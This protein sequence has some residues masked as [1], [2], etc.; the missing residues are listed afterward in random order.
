MCGV[1]LVSYICHPSGLPNPLLRLTI[2]TW[3]AHRASQK[4]KPYTLPSFPIIYYV[5]GIFASC[6]HYF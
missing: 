4:P 6:P 2:R 1:T 5:V 3:G